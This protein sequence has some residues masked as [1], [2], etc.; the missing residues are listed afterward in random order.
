MTQSPNLISDEL[1]DLVA[2]YCDDQLTDAQLNQLEDLLRANPDH[3]RFFLDYVDIHARLC[4]EARSSG[5]LEAALN[6]SPHRTIADAVPRSVWIATALALSVLI[7]LVWSPW[8]R[9]PA[10]S[11][12]SPPPD[13]ALATVVQAVGRWGDQL[14]AVHPGY[15]LKDGIFELPQGVVEIAWPSGVHMI[16][17]SPARLELLDGD[18]V[19]LHSGR[20]VTRVPQAGVDFVIETD[21]VR[22]KDAGTEFGVSVGLN[23]STDVQVYEGAVDAQ[24]LGPNGQSQPGSRLQAGEAFSFDSTPKKLPF[25][26]ERFLRRFP[27]TPPKSKT[28]LPFNRSRIESVHAQLAKQPPTIDGDLREWNQTKAFQVACLA[29]YDEAYRAEGTIRYDQDRIYIAMH[30]SDPS[31]MTS[32]ADPFNEPEFFWTGGSVILRVGANDN[33]GWPLN[34]AKKGTRRRGRPIDS[35][36]DTSNQV[37][38]IGM[39]YSKPQQRS[40]LMLQ[41]GIGCD[42]NTL[43]SEGWQGAYR[44][45]PDGL[46]Y[47][48]EYAIDYKLLNASPPKPGDVWP[49]TLAIHWSDE[50]GRTCMGRLV[51]ITNQDQLP[52]QTFDAATWGK[53][54]FQP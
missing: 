45:D 6:D 1:K 9:R 23:G 2:R 31:P 5:D 49:S 48:F 10:S 28:E 15:Q 35:A 37:V 29:P 34:A 24:T 21:R 30:V 13:L 4:W 41:Y 32:M 18:A 47:T 27:E 39:W 3:Q 51:E 46:G 38:H 40:Q 17:E 19:F 26:P 12:V 53:L 52:F 11:T 50:A 43:P 54:V 42:E 22:L 33:L 8:Q 36:K 20:V 25:A 44:R 7:V 14:E 16:L